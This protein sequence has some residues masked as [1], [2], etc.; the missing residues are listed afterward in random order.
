MT[1]GVISAPTLVANQT[2]AKAQAVGSI[3]TF[4]GKGSQQCD[5]DG[6]N[7]HSLFGNDDAMD[8]TSV[9]MAGQ[10]TT[11]VQ[12]FSFLSGSSAAD[13]MD[14]NTVSS[15]TGTLV[16]A[17]GDFEA[18]TVAGIAFRVNSCTVNEQGDA[19]MTFQVCT[20]PA[21]G[22][23]IVPPE[24]TMVCSTDP[25]SPNFRPKDG[26]SC[27]RAA[28]S[29]EP[30]GSL[31]GWSN[32]LTV[33]YVQSVAV[34]GTEDQ[35]AANG[36]GM[37]FYPALGAGI[38]ANFSADSDNM[39]AVKVVQTAINKDTRQSALG[40]RVAFRHKTVVTKEMMIQGTSAVPN[41][42]EHTAS[43]DT[44]LKLQGNP[45]I[46][47]YQK[48]YA[49]NGS[50][51]VNQIQEG[52]ATDGIVSVCDQSYTNESGIRPQALTAQMAAEGQ[53]C[54]TSTQCLQ[55]I[56]NTNTW[57]QTCSAD[58]PLSI[59]KCTT[60]TDYDLEM[61]SWVR[62][63]NK[64]QCTETR[65][66]NTYNC[67]SY[68]EID[69]CSQVSV[70]SN[71][72][73]QLGADQQDTRI[74]KVGDSD[75]YTSLY[76]FGTVGNDYWPTGYYSRTFTLDIIDAADV[77]K[78]RLYHLGFDDLIAVSINGVWVYSDYAG[79]FYHPA[80]DKWGID[81]D[82]C[83]RYVDDN[84]VEWVK[85]LLP[86]WE[87]RTSWDYDVNVNMIPYLRNGSNIIRIDTGVV[88]GGEGWAFFEISAWKMKCTTRTI[89]ECTQY[90]QAK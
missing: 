11:G 40:L 41:P 3:T 19:Q 65:A 14:T 68:N 61:L 16:L 29:T 73:L 89:N 12:A 27:A 37:A 34:S 64:E 36:L 32:P 70:I 52:L 63:K 24:K 57:E 45:L 88:G 28:C 66:S 1:N 59:R 49:A 43:W 15:Q 8:Y 81:Q 6:K 38:P 85:Q 75:A 9:Q 23:P 25:A 42:G 78:F 2:I 80:E 31:N 77:K 55:E 69:S 44:I 26:Y 48:T 46:P 72:G 67:K 82:A 51:C 56:V 74:T 53:A 33:S 21:R 22:N 5:D 20:G 90:E 76:R 87:R 4:M 13:K 60:K 17:C 10:S 83:G 86:Y 50:E 39:T 71:G 30:T 58:V 84:C 47:Q 54:G 18:K 62:T 79:G 7:C 35:K